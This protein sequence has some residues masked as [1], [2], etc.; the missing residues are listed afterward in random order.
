MAWG[1]GAVRP[2]WYKLDGQ[3]RR[4]AKGSRQPSL[5]PQEELALMEQLP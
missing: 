5:E 2:Q 4:G 3:Q 1:R